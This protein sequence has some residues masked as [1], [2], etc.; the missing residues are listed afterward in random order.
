VK[1][2]ALLPFALLCG[3]TGFA[4]QPTD[5]FLLIGQSNMAGRGV[6][7]AA[8]RTPITGVFM[9]NEAKQWVP[10]VDPMHFDRPAIIGVGLGRTFAATLLEL[11]ATNSVGLIPAAFGGSAL[12][13]W[14][15]GS[16]HYLNAVERTRAALALAGPNARLRGILWHQG[17]ADS[18][19][20][21]RAATY[22]KRFQRF[23]ADLRQD[24]NAANV[25][26]VVGEL[27]RFV[28]DRPNFPNPYAGQVNE[29][30]ATLP[31]TVPLCGFV[32]SQG[33]T[34]KGDALHFDSRSMR[35]Y[36]RRYALAWLAL[37]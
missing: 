4:Q 27:G 22:G 10:A 37:Q 17:E 12:E 18:T 20:A 9:F 30:L 32:S 6:V 13:E 33:L 29:Q 26:V 28:H 15:K 3:F 24:L 11:R 35:E 19:S 23:I 1:L 36:G 8:D 14:T 5:V 7:E 21:D 2:S 31:L 34:H 16:M 25:P